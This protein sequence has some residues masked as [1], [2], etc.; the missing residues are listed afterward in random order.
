M[1]TVSQNPQSISSTQAFTDLVAAIDRSVSPDRAA[2][3][4]ADFRAEVL[5]EAADIA[6]AQRQFE[7]TSGPR[8]SAQISENVGILRV[9]GKLR[10]L[11]RRL[12]G[13][14]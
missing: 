13:T 3:L 2:E 10:R 4:L 6:D 11:A 8:K 12:G 14:R 9:S 1:S 7:R 5:R